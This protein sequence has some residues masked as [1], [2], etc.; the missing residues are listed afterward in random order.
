[1]NKTKSKI[2]LTII[3]VVLVI[4]LAMTF[5][6]FPI[7]IYDYNS[8]IGAVDLDYDLAGGVSYVLTY[9]KEN[10]NTEISDIN[11][12]I[13]TLSAR[14]S[15]LGYKSYKI[16]AFKDANKAV[17]DYSI[18][19][20]AK[21]TS[22]VDSDVK[23]VAA[24][25]TIKFFGGTESDPTTEI[26][27]EEAAV[28]SAKYNGQ[29]GS[30][31]ITALEFTDYAIKELKNQLDE[32]SEYY[33]KITL[34]DQTLL[35][36]SL[37]L[38]GLT[39]NTVYITATSESGAKQTAMQIATGGLDYR[40]EVSDPVKA[41]P[42]YGENAA[43]KAAIAVGVLLVA[44]MAVMIVMFGGYGVI[45]ALSLLVFALTETSMLV[46]VPG[47]S[48][49]LLGVIGIA[50]SL[51]LAADGLIIT[52]KRIREEFALGKTVKASVKTGYKRAFAPVL[53]INVIAAV[54]AL[55][56]FALTGGAFNCFAI[57]LGI[58]AVISF[59]INA[60]IS[61]MFL[62]VILPL[63]DNKE[64]FLNLKRGDE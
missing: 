60:L 45:S 4:W 53:S 15:A 23:A 29:S 47:I 19:I 44:I 24:Y 6:R 25:G 38:N 41:Q 50:L 64:K 59:L 12:V 37:S 26:L 7:G 35:S 39:K 52:V 3:S 32:N 34:G 30:S 36:S 16:T 43:L 61:K 28:K 20:S 27:N 33:L 5:V 9:D 42:L 14:M 58:G 31:Y 22:S 10:E 62:N 57:T 11:E 55:V 51:V 1:M 49:S 63:C 48:L 2:L 17:K 21:E 18:R 40:Y 13:G 54:V 8:I 46:A 56:L